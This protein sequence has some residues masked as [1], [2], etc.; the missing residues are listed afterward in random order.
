MSLE[1]SVYLSVYW[2][3]YQKVTENKI[4]LKIEAVGNRMESLESLAVLETL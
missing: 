2:D 3:K 1:C 4:Q